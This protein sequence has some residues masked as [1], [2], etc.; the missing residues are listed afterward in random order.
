MLDA[1]QGALKDD[2]LRMAEATAA[3][4]RVPASRRSVPFETARASGRAWTRAHWVTAGILAWILLFGASLRLANVNW[5]ICNS[6]QARLRSSGSRLSS[7]G[8]Q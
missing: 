3:S 5:A 2:G 1:E 7:H 6:R 8:C 4:P